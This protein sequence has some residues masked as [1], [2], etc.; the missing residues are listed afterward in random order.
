MNGLNRATILGNL[1][2]DPELKDTS[3]GPVCRLSVATNRQWKDK[4]G[5]E[6]KHT[7]WHRVV[8][9]GKQ[10]ENAA[11][12]LKKGSQVYIEGRL[13]TTKWEDEVDG[14]K[15]TRWT[16]EIVA[17]PFGGVT[18]LGSGD[19]S[20]ARPPDP[21]DDATENMDQYEPLKD[22]DISF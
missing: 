9:F 7:E 5:N 20:S 2:G 4:Q 21:P 19:G 17:S 14:K 8:I 3:A 10:A 1:G 13:Q 22:D 18:F 16:T 11:K 12:Y 6:K 15:V